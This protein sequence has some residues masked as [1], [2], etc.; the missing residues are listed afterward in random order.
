MN[1]DHPRFT[2]WDAAYVLG[3]L[4][5][6]DRREFED[7]LDECPD[8][9]RAIADLTSTV[10]LLSRVTA[11]DVEQIDEEQIG[12][13]RTDA[14]ESPD[15]A[16]RP[17]EVL[18]LARERARRRRRNRL[19]ALIAAAVLVIAAV[20]VPLTMSSLTR[21]SE[22]FALSATTGIPLQA[23]V[24]ITPVAWGTRLDL[25]CR[26]PQDDSSDAPEEGWTYALAVVDR[27]GQAET[28][29]TWRA[30][31]GS[32]SRLSAGTALDVDD[33]RSVEIRAMNG[34][35][36]MSYDLESDLG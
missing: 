4:S 7:H 33:I 9:R 5:P 17:A 10:G 35:V 23:S 3:A 16:V 19:V 15:A 28:L 20:A 2:Q 1:P 11:E 21:P 27:S 12:D 34:T 13:E 29:S 8:C 14:E 22:S 25:D 24:R 26:Y 18:E 32:N 36:L 30:G 31:P 6:A